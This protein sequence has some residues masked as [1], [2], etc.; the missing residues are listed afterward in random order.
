MA[1]DPLLVLRALR[2][3]AVEQARRGLAA[4][5]KV[6]IEAAVKI[7]ELSEAMR[8]DRLAGEDMPNAHQFLELFAN[9]LSAIRAQRV[10][11]VE[12]LAV[13]QTQVSE[14]RA[15][16]VAERTKAEA[17]EQLIA[18]QKTA[19]VVAADSKAQ[20]EMDDIARA[21]NAVRRGGTI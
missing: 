1:R 16:V 18:E 7:D 12:A 17:V 6:E 9:R 3:R 11:A 5:L 19:R 15:V 21:A 8:C 10:A 20:H 14:A 2:Q 4:C 13:A